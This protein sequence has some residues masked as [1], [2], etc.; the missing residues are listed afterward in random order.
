VLGLLMSSVGLGGI[1]GGLVTASLG[2]IERRGLLQLAALLL[3][4][5]ALIGFA[6]SPTLLVAL[7]LLSLAGFAEMIFLT[8]NQTLLQLSI[9][10]ELRGRVT[11][12]VSLNAGLSP[13]GGLLAGAGADLL[14]PRSITVLLCSI[15]GLVALATLIGSA[16]IRDYRLSRAL[17]GRGGER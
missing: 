9:P 6:L 2:R 14:G 4:S 11:G 1:V 15:A 13:L 16:T 8:T 5:L 7:P 10:D 12:I 3:T 17:T